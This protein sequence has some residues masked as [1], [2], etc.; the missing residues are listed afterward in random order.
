MTYVYASHYRLQRM[1]KN[2]IR[3]HM[4]SN[5]VYEIYRYQ[6]TVEMQE[7]PNIILT[8]GEIKY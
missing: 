1:H 2:I 7:I 4:N 6:Y 8:K 3:I 5:T